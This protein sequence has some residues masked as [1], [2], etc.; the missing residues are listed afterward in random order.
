ME[1]LLSV[2]YGGGMSLCT[3]LYFAVS[4]VRLVMVIKYLATFLICKC[5]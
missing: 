2:T 4:L 5:I 1:S 3:P